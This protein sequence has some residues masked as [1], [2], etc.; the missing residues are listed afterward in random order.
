M[1]EVVHVTDPADPRLADY[2][3]LT[4]VELRQRRE[5]AEGLFMAEGDKIVRRALEAGCAARSV[6]L[7]PRWLDRMGD[8]LAGVD[9]PVY[10]APDE[11]LERVSGYRVHRGPLAAMRRPAPIDPVRLVTTGRHVLVLEDVVDH[12]NVGAV[13]RTAAAFAF[14]GVLLSPRCADPLYRRAVKVSMGAVLSVPWARLTDWY[15]APDLLR[16]AGLRSLA[17]TPAADAVDLPELAPDDLRRCA[18]LLGAEG[19]GLSGH[20]MRAADLRVRVPI[21]SKVDSL[22]VAAAAAVACYAVAVSAR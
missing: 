14:D 3:D 1:P 9:S 16:I 4:D 7:A 12:A 17:L 18:L 15:A 13:F 10:V 19:D 6:L 20:W 22:N 5:P 2:V 21:S 11:V 8:A